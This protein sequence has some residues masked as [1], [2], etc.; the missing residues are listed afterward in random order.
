MSEHHHHPGSVL[1]LA[2]FAGSTALIGTCLGLAIGARRGPR[3]TSRIWNA[4][5]TAGF[6]KIGL[7][8]RHDSQAKRTAAL[9]Y[10]GVLPRDFDPIYVSDTV[11]SQTFNKMFDE[12]GF[13]AVQLWQGH[14]KTTTS[15]HELEKRVHSNKWCFLRGHFFA[16]EPPPAACFYLNLRKSGTL[17]QKLNQM[18]ANEQHLDFTELIPLSSVYL[19][20]WQV[21][22]S[23]RP[24]CPPS[25]CPREVP[26]CGIRH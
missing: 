20:K 3:T 25:P 26:S 16:A 4:T 5:F 6:H 9:M 22:P 7:L 10:Y 24:I 18:F 14:G 13:R 17:E 23:L 19:K 8:S 15:M 2:R 21:L 12:A 1:L 11:I